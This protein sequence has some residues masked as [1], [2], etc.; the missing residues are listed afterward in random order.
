ML[1]EMIVEDMLFVE[2]FIVVGQYNVGDCKFELELYLTV[3][4]VRVEKQVDETNNHII[5]LNFVIH[6]SLE[7]VFLPLFYFFQ[8]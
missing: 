1:V 2:Q 8:A 6:M 3:M 7:F 5:V 4:A